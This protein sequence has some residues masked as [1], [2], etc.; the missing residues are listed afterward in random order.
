MAK[1]N[2]IIVVT[3]LGVLCAASLFLGMEHERN[4]QSLSVGES[5][6]PAD[7]G[8]APASSPKR[9]GEGNYSLD[10]PPDFVSSRRSDLGTNYETWHSGDNTQLI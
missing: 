10:V 7:G 4:V 2:F 3:S 9:I 1:R 5:T 8:A 6:V